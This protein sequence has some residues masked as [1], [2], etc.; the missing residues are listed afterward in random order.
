[1][2]KLRGIDNSEPHLRKNFELDTSI[3]YAVC[4]AKGLTVMFCARR[5]IPTRMPAR[6]ET[7]TSSVASSYPVNRPGR[8]IF[9]EYREKEGN[10]IILQEFRD[11]IWYMVD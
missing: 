1:M 5:R 8:G 7:S 6:D 3:S 4:V 11:W 9:A 10:A 2:R